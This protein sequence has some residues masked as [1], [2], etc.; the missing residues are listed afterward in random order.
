LARKRIV[1]V[2]DRTVTV[3]KKDNVDVRP[4]SQQREPQACHLRKRTF[5]IRV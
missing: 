5:R 3:A 2:R 1:F 4:D